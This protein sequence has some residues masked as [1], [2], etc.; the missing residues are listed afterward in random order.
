MAKL[1]SIHPLY[2]ALSA[3]FLF[4]SPLGSGLVLAISSAFPLCPSI[5]F[6]V[7]LPL[8]LTPMCFGKAH[9][10]RRR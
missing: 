7:V 1:I 10:C 5:F 6:S 9:E 8:A 4:F 3:L 2:S